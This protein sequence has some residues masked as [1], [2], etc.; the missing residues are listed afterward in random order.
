MP[1]EQERTD[2]VM[3]ILPTSAMRQKASRLCFIPSRVTITSRDLKQA[4]SRLLPYPS[5]NG[6]ER[7][8]LDIR[9]QPTI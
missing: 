6:A 1:P 2:E 4:L 8:A 3:A 7:P 9:L 5:Q